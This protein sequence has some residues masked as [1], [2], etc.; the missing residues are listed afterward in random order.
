MRWR[1]GFK[2]V[3]G[4]AAVAAGIGLWSYATWSP[5]TVAFDSPA[6]GVSFH[7]PNVRVGDSIWLGLP[8]LRVRHGIKRVTITGLSFASRYPGVSIRATGRLSLAQTGDRLITTASDHEL[9][10]DSIRIVG[11]YVGA[12]EVPGDPVDYGAVL[13]MFSE[14]GTFDIANVVLRYRVAGRTGEQRI[15]CDYKITVSR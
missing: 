12:T 10:V 9:Q 5:R 4:A 8:P 14:P 7:D 13:T 3:V 6:G 11:P 2:P 15:P 1:G